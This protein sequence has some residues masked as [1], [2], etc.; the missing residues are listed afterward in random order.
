M[1]K[2]AVYIL[3]F[4]IYVCNHITPA[5]SQKFLKDIYPGT[6]SANYS[7]N[8]SYKGLF[9]FSATD[10]V[11]GQELWKS[12]GTPSGTVLLKDIL[13]GPGDSY[14][15]AFAILND[16]VYFSGRDYTS[17][18]QLWK[19][20]GTTAGTVPVT[21]IPGGLD[22]RILE[23]TTVNS[24]LFFN[25]QTNT[26]GRE[27]WKSNG[28]AAGTML[29]KD[30]LPGK[31][32]SYSY[33]F[34]SCNNLLFF[35]ADDS[36]SQSG[37]ELWR[38]DGTAAG[39]IL[40]KDINPGMPSSNPQVLTDVNGTLFF[41][42]NDGVHGVELWK[43]DGTPSGTV[44]VKDIYVG[45]KSSDP[46][47]FVNAN[48]TLFFIAT[49][50]TNG[51]ELWKSDGTEA[52][53]VMVKDINPGA[54]NSYPAHLIQQNGIV[55]FN[56]T[57]GV[58]GIELW[59]SDGTA[60]GTV[61]IA[62]A[63]PGSG[64]LMPS[65]LMFNGDQLFFQGVTPATG[66]ELW[67]SDTTSEGT[68]LVKDIYPGTSSSIPSLFA[69]NSSG[70]FFIAD[71]GKT[72][73]EL[74]VVSAPLPISK[75][76]LSASKICIGESITFTDKSSGNPT[77][78]LW[79]FSG[80]VNSTSSKQNTTVTFN[81]AGTYTAVLTTSNAKGQT[82]SITKTVTVMPLPVVNAGPD[83]SICKGNCTPLTGKGIGSYNWAPATGLSC[84]NCLSPISCPVTTTS[85]TLTVT[86]SNHCKAQDAVIVSHFPAPSINA[87][88]STSICEGKTVILS[89]PG[90]SNYLWSTGDTTG[91]ISVTPT[92]STSYQVS[93]IDSHG[94][95]DTIK[96]LI[97]VNKLP[98]IH[99]EGYAKI[100]FGESK[101]LNA[102][103]GD[104]YVWSPGGQTTA[105]I[106]VSPSQTTTYTVTG[107]DVNGCSNSDTATIIV[108]ICTGIESLDK[109]D[110][111]YVYPNPSNGQFTIQSDEKILLIDIMNM[112]GE[113]IYTSQPVTT[114]IDIDLSPQRKGIY[115]ARLHTSKGIINRKISI[116]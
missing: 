50:G 38:S 25:A 79:K 106:L 96:Q 34:K 49:D 70:C 63:V 76:S 112:L 41:F 51:Y 16:T 35:L 28:T 113:H 90:G 65:F 72:G 61:M 84:T 19:T 33:G 36:L 73:P 54:A 55:Y 75:F 77:S 9:L 46:A 109:G 78:W 110:M 85:Y 14:P 42:A 29:V 39:T 102:T 32:S 105:S 17:Q 89:V 40:L 69:S 66:Q 8:I 116:Q 27:L 5:F 101:L 92:V 59:K 58:H 11:K 111:S 20:D 10:G 60:T 86:D 94:C 82:T 6:M 47:R 104:S 4:I 57:D 95:S 81:S 21:N 100:C 115:L 108:I 13:S 45:T 18:E 3:L 99:A 12:D 31:G 74:W 68:V 88:P 62:D 93:L 56:A 103:G 7:T 2:K 114:D 37:T 80:P 15:L 87:N 91:T 67:V 44:L 52:G 83:I 48:G 30:I 53:T 107:K 64:N 98:L 1:R 97:T 22:Y 71:D 43:S 23:I 24:T 26:T